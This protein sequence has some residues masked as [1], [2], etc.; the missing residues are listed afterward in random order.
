MSEKNLQQLKQKKP[1]QKLRAR[2]GGVSEELKMKTRTQ[3]SI[4]KKI[5]ES[6]ENASKT[7]PEIAQITKIPSHEVLWYL[8][9]LKKYGMVIEGDEQEGYYQYTLKEE[10]KK[11]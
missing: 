2:Y 4:M 3:T 9:A 5:K 8:M 7:V 10:E 1:I 6:I 11:K